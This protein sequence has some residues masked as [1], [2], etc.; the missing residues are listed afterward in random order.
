M[1]KK[2]FKYI[3]MHKKYI[4]LTFSSFFL[5]VNVVIRIIVVYWKEPSRFDSFFLQQKIAKR[6]L[7]YIHL[8]KK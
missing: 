1:L 2:P 4:K 3:Y 7:I 6:N 8:N 5:L